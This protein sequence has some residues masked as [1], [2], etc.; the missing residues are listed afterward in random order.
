MKP[1]LRAVPGRPVATCARCGAGIGRDE[2]AWIEHPEGR[3]AP[4]AAVT[5]ESV[6]RAHAAHVWHLL[7]WADE[8][9]A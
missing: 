2:P 1:P 7:C 4:S 3:L 6:D 5:E 9:A 8:F